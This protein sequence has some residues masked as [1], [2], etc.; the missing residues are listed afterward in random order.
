MTDAVVFRSIP[1][2]AEYPGRT[3]FV[4]MLAKDE[5]VL[6]AI[7]LAGL[8]H[9]PV[10]VEFAIIRALEYVAHYQRLGDKIY[11]VLISSGDTGDVDTAY[12]TLYESHGGKVLVDVRRGDGN[13]LRAGTY[14]PWPSEP[15]GT[16]Y[17]F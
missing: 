1:E 3:M 6:A 17:K 5:T 7:P 16:V 8:A 13:P 14:G 11:T 2:L 12:A 10:H 15:D 4:A 9:E